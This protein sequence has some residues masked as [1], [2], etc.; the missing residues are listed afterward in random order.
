MQKK[1]LTLNV[2]YKATALIVILLPVVIGLGFWQLARAEEKSQLKTTYQQ[3]QQADP[4]DIRSLKNQ[5]DLLYK[6]VSITGRYLNNKNILLDNKIYQG[7]FGYE[8]LTAFSVTDS[9]LVVWVNRGWIAGDRSRRQLP[10]I[11]SI[12]EQPLTINAE[13]Y[14]PQ[15]SL[16]QLSSSTEN[17]LSQS[18]KVLQQFEVKNNSDFDALVF[19]YSVRLNS[20]QAGVLVRNWLLVNVQPEK[21]IAYAIQWF[22]MAIMLVIMAFLANTNAWQLVKRQNNS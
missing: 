7:I 4:V 1:K 21:H 16:L 20:S 6:Q 14:V 8:V 2:D 3:R 18:I 10:V 9:D 13:V 15:G 17:T 12:L 11:E 5:H 22:A 19:P